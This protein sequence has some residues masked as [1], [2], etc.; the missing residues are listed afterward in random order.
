MSQTPLNFLF[1]G[2]DSFSWRCHSVMSHSEERVMKGVC[3]SLLV[4]RQSKMEKKKKVKQDKF[5]QC[6]NLALI[7]TGLQ[8][9]SSINTPKKFWYKMFAAGV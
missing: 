5:F 3:W 1:C 8:I 4:R 7:C 2:L 6:L 9:K